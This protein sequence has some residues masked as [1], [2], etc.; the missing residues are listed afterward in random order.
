MPASHRRVALVTGGSRGIGLGIARALAGDQW[1]LAINGVRAE[2]EVQA[3]LD[4]LRRQGADAI[5]CQG[6]VGQAED[7]ASIV[8]T[9]KAHFGSA[10]LLVNNKGFTS[11]GRGKST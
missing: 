2:A 6:D 7:R 3:V 4:D 9:V 10:H 11:H 1:D 8:A 5:Y